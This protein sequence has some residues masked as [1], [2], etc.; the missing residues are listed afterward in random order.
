MITEIMPRVFA[1]DTCSLNRN[2]DRRAT[3]MKLNAMKGYISERSAFLRAMIRSTDANAYVTNPAI[4]GILAYI[5]TE[6]MR[7]VAYLRRT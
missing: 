7:V 6:D 2:I 5:G 1:K 3:Q 4:S